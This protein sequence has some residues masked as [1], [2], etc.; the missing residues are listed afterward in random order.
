MY[1][2]EKTKIQ[3]TKKMVLIER[4][5]EMK[6][7]QWWEEADTIICQEV[8]DY[9]YIMWLSKSLGIK[10]KK[11]TDDKWVIRVMRIA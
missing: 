7:Y 5:Q 1:E 3:K 10:L 4:I 2:I 11:I 6:P 8:S 9:T